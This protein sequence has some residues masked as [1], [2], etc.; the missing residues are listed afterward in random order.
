M[1]DTTVGDL[2]NIAFNNS[3]E[4]LAATPLVACSV[5]PSR[6]HLFSVVL[7]F[8]SLMVFTLAVSELQHL[9]SCICKADLG[10]SG[11]FCLA[12]SVTASQVTPTKGPHRG[13]GTPELTCSPPL[14]TVLCAAPHEMKWFDLKI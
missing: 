11:W 2:R 3:V 14:W 7:F 12:V 6:G 13:L 5:I 1:E 4:N 9:Y 10:I 8:F